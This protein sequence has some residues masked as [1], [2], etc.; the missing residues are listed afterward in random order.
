[1]LKKLLKLLLL[2]IFGPGVEYIF[3]DM[4]KVSDISN[5]DTVN[6]ENISE[7]TIKE[8]LDWTEVYGELEYGKYQVSLSDSNL[9]LGINI[10]FSIDE[11][12]IISY[13]EPEILY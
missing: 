11:S 7:D 8:T 10:S 12:G 1:M 4:E 6:I 5:E 9:E 2:H 13:N 3:K